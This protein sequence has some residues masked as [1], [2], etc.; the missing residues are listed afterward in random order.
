[1]LSL[2]SCRLTF[3][4]DAA[5]TWVNMMGMYPDTPGRMESLADTNEGYRL[6]RAVVQDGRQ[7]EIVTPIMSDFFQCEKMMVPK[8]I[9]VINMLLADHSQTLF[10]RR[11]G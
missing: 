5:K 3:G 2:P 11:W 1:M 6:R 4:S 8:V 10:S 9:I 7:F